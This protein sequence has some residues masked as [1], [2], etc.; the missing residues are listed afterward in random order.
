MYVLTGNQT[1]FII[2]FTAP[3]DRVEEMTSV[4]TKV[5]ETMKIY[6]PDDGA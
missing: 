4:F 2:T 3:A 6:Q 1:A 5:A